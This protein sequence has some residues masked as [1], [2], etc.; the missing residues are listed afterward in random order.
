MYISDEKKKLVEGMLAK[1][2]TCFHKLYICKQCGFTY[3]LNFEIVGV[4]Q[5][6]MSYHYQ[7]KVLNPPEYVAADQLNK[8]PAWYSR[9]PKCNSQTK[10]VSIEGEVSEKKECNDVCTHATGHI[11]KCSCGGHNHGKAYDYKGENN[12]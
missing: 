6:G 3:R 12:V 2:G 10:W 9:C 8:F 4:K 5:D 1:V 11:C 7:W